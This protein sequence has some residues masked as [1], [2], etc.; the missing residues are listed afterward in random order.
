LEQHETKGDALTVL[1]EYRGFILDGGGVKADGTGA[2]GGGHLR[3]SA[4]RKEVLLEVDVDAGIPGGA[5]E[6]NGGQGFTLR[7]ALDASGRLLI[8][9]GGVALYWLID[10]DAVAQPP[11]AFAD[12]NAVA[13]FLRSHREGDAVEK[14]GLQRMTTH[15]MLFGAGNVVGEASFWSLD[16]DFSRGATPAERPLHR[17]TVGFLVQ[18]KA[19]A[20][21]REA[22]VDE[23]FALTLTHEV[24]HLLIDPPDVEPWEPQTPGTRDPLG[25][26]RTEHHTIA[27]G[28]VALMYRIAAKENR[29]FATA[30]IL[31][32]TLNLLRVA[33]NA[34]LSKE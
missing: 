31:P 3:L 22:P 21:E 9:D 14:K 32:V 18:A 19:A 16:E 34:G 24:V 12:A 11:G 13:D 7:S 4:A 6:K 27:D 15:V 33:E 23:Y 30:K 26:S 10:E 5:L 20:Q 25:K 17:G 1:T 28:G 8:R 2:H 29:S